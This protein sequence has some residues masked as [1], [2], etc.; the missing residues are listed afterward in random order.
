MYIYTLY[1]TLTNFNIKCTKLLLLI[2][3]V[4]PKTNARG[5]PVG[6]RKY[7]LETFNVDITSKALPLAYSFQRQN[8]DSLS[9]LPEASKLC[10]F[11]DC[12]AGASEKAIRL[13]C[14]HTIHPSCLQMADDHCPICSRPLFNEMKR[15]SNSFNESLLEPTKQSPGQATTT[16]PTLNFDDEDELPT[17]SQNDET[18]TYYQTEAW[19]RKIDQT[20]DSFVVP[21]PQPQQRQQPTQTQQQSSGQGQQH[22]SHSPC[23]AATSF[24]QPPIFKM[25]FGTSIIWFFPSQFSQ[26]TLYGRNGSN[27]CTFIALLLAKFYFLHKSALSLS[28]YMSLPLNCINLFINFISLGNHIYDSVTT[29][30][31]RYISVQEATPFLTPYYWQVQ[32]ED[33]FDLSILNENPMVP[34]CSLA[35]CLEW[36]TNEGSLAAVVIMNSMAISLVRQNNNQI[37]MDSHLHCQLSVQW[38]A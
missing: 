1:T 5:K 17:T 21:Q 32:L 12:S 30:I 36:L 20:L 37:V 4:P 13:S 38:L 8:S 23:N 11:K 26:S 3:Q 33:S 25:G 28:Q 18:S 2:F 34:Q 14:F 16:D 27:A 22:S 24:N 9:T 15:L 6:E 29:G 35:F 10:D 7:H 31:G 19:K